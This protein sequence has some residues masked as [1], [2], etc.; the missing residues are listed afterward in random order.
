[1]L[2]PSTVFL[3]A[4]LPALLLV[5]YLAPRALRN[6]ILLLASLLFYAWG[7]T[8]YVLLMLFAVGANYLFGL[9]IAASDAG[10]RRLWVSLAVAANLGLLGWFKYANFLVDNLNRALIPLGFAAIELDPVHLPL[11]ISFFMFQ[12]MSYV[13]DVYRGT[14]EVQR[15]PDRVAL[16]ISLFP[17]L[18]AGPIVRYHDVAQQ[19][20]HRFHESSLF[21]SGARRFVLGLAKKLL[22]ANTVGEVADTVFAT[23]AGELGT[24]LAW[25][26]IVCY[27]L[28]IYF[29]FSAYSDMAIGLGRMFGFRFLE[30]FNYPYIARSLRDFWRRWHI[31]LSRWFRDYLYI[32][33]GGNRHSAGRTYANLCIVFLLCGFWHGASWNFIV[34]GAIHGAFLAIER[35]GLERLLARLPAPLGHIY[36][37]L[38]VLFAWVYFRAD[39]LGHANDYAL[40]LLGLH[41]GHS[42][43]GTVSGLLTADVI[44]ALAAGILFS[45]PVYRRLSE[46]WIIPRLAGGG[47]A[48][49][50]SQLLM[51]AGLLLV[52]AAFV[53]AGTYNPFIYFRF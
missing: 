33:L 8:V 25:L 18:I 26:G 19:L 46:R 37:L 22:I 49:G 17:Q 40:A 30:N 11:G 32:P 29:D 6:T 2:F 42:V 12:A 10:R 34:W 5:Y 15:R 43:P 50:A 20:A 35:A 36:T 52:S 31:S 47:L 16:Y 4:F 28:Q 13:V 21:V 27:A 53:A 41:A 9:A 38:V 39:N 48:Y 51:I 23:P 3:F 1:M 14:C 7:E 44:A 45:M 24:M